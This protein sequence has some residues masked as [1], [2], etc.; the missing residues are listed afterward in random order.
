MIDFLE[1]IRTVTDTTR[2]EIKD[3][4][5]D[6]AARKK[7]LE[8]AEIEKLKQDFSTDFLKGKMMEAAH[9]GWA[10][11]EMTI[12]KDVESQNP[13]WWPAIAKHIEKIAKELGVHFSKSEDR[14]LRNS[15]QSSLA[16]CSGKISLYWGRQGQSAYGDD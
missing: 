2:A 13:H 16:H 6:T 4:I 5:R 1:A 14:H 10:R 12:F 9:E 7:A 3:G 15:S 8:E 11:I